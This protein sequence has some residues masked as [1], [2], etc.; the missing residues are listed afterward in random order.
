LVL[1]GDRGGVSLTLSARS[2]LGHFEGHN[3]TRRTKSKRYFLR[4]FR[5]GMIGFANHRSEVRSGSRSEGPG[6]AYDTRGFRRIDCPLCVSPHRRGSAASLGLAALSPNQPGCAA[7]TISTTADDVFGLLH[8]RNGLRNGP[9]SR[10]SMANTSLDWA[11]RRLGFFSF[12]DLQEK[13]GEENSPQC[14]AR[15]NQ[16]GRDSPGYEY[17]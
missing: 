14:A 2:R 1:A 9:L 16:I 15:L 7:H 13:A 3:I 12:L 6:Y 4:P 5:A 11:F 8:P 10:V 17:L